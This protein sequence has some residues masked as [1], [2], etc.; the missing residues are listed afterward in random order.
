MA[1]TFSLITTQTLNSSAAG[2]T[3]TMPTGYTDVQINYSIRSDRSG[4]VADGM[5]VQLNS[6]TTAGNYYRCTIYDEGGTIGGEGKFNGNQFGVAP[7]ANANS[8]VFNCGTMYI[9]NYSDTQTKI[10]YNYSQ[11]NNGGGT[12]TRYMWRSFL[13]WNSSSALTTVKITSANAANYIAGSEISIYGI[14]KA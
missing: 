12:S 14:K 3:I 2:I 4:Q 8:N 6:D 11:F 7:S 9:P 13:T 1:N 5:I 10:L